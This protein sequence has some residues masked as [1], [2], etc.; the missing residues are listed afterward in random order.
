MPGRSIH[1]HDH[2]LGQGA[3]PGERDSDLATFDHMD[4]RETITLGSRAQQR[5]MVLTHV[6]AGSL[7]LA[8]AAG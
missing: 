4:T 6:L 8:D 1:Q 7:T 3:R 5:L 2:V